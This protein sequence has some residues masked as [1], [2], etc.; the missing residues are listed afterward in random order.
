LKNEWI[1]IETNSEL[2]R[3]NH[4]SIMVEA[5]PHWRFF[6]FGGCE[7]SYQEGEK[8]NPGKFSNNVQLYNVESPNLH[9]L[10]LDQTEKD[11]KPEK[12][13]L[14]SLLYDIKRRRMIVFGGYSN[15]W[16]DDL[17]SLDVS[18]VVGPS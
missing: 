6:I 16:L 17:W 11:P 2:A 4:S 15:E 14:C 5:I 7:I 10:D 1:E 9:P 8:R 12:R 13:E 18:Q 3:W